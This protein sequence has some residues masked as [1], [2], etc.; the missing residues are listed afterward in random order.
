MITVSKAKKQCTIISDCYKNE[1]STG[2]NY[3][4]FYAAFCQIN[5]QLNTNFDK[6]IT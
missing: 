2:R 1:T 3:P 6:F 4:F 5:K